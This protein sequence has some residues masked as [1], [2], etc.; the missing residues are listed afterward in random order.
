MYGFK[1]LDFVP[2]TPE[3]IKF[4]YFE[5]LFCQKYRS[6]AWIKII[7]ILYI[8]SEQNCKFFNVVFFSKM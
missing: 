7:E 3:F 6:T 8:T 1:L 2:W 4:N 5:H